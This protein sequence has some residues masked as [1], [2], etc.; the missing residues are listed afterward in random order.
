MKKKREKKLKKQ[1]IF[2]EKN[3]EKKMFWNFSP[4]KNIWVA[5]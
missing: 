2:V 4:K 3:L 5:E 1:N